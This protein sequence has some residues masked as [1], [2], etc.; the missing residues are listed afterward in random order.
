LIFKVFLSPFFFLILIDIQ[1][2]LWFSF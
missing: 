2:L 1:L